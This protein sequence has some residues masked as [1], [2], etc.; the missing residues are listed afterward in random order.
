M[1]TLRLPIEERSVAVARGLVRDAVDGQHTAAVEDAVLMVSELVSNA[2]RYTEA[3][4]VVLISVDDRTLRV[5]VTDDNPDL[6]RPADP[7]DHA[8]S[9]R[10]LHIVDVLADDWGF[11]PDGGGKT[12]W[13][14]IHL[15]ADAQPRGSASST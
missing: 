4:L 6:P 8:T 9:G 3:V 14:E 10:G 1:P 11:T 15:D 5:E 13:F 12:V 2:V 7:H